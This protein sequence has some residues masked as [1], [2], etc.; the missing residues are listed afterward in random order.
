[1]QIVPSRFPLD[2]NWATIVIR[3]GGGGKSRGERRTIETSSSHLRRRV[4]EEPL[5]RKD[6]GE[7][8]RF[9][10][11]VNGKDY[12]Y[13]R[14][15]LSR[16]FLQA[17][18]FRGTFG[19]YIPDSQIKIITRPSRDGQQWQTKDKNFPF[20]REFIAFYAVQLITR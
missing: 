5:L 9:A 15:I 20:W 11:Y 8:G 17:N 12:R 16:S 19:R 13:R 3:D 10:R 2:G 1:M 18:S 14:E 6:R 4:E 7:A